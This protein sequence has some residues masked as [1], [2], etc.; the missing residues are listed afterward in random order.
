[1]FSQIYTDY[2]SGS[3]GDAHI[4]S[5]SIVSDIH[6]HGSANGVDWNFSETDEDID[7]ALKNNKTTSPL[8]IWLA[9]PY[10]EL[11]LFDA[12]KFIDAQNNFGQ[13]IGS[14]FASNMTTMA[15]HE[16]VIHEVLVA[17]TLL[18]KSSKQLFCRE[19]RCPRCLN[20]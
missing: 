14:H 19:R 7:Y 12:R 15:R 17:S 20:C 2:Q 4:P 9:N 16:D 3:V 18:Y 6:T 11:L 13:K 8:N 10:G 1:M 5:A